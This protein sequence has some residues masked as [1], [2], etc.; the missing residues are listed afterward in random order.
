MSRFDRFLRRV[1]PST[2]LISRSAVF[3]PVLAVSDIVGRGILRATGKHQAVPP[4][5]YIVRTGVG[6]S[7]F[8]PHDYYLT[9]SYP[10]WMYL[11]SRGLASLHSRIV[12]IGSGVGKSAVGLRDFA[13]NGQRF[14]GFYQGYD[15]DPEMV[16]W[17]QANFPSDRFSFTKLDMANSLYSPGQLQRERPALTCESGTIDLVISQSLFSH[18][19]E[20]DIRHY[21][22]ESYRVLRPGGAMLMTFFCLDDMRDQ[23][24]LGGRWTFQHSIGAAQVENPRY[25]ESAVAYRK[26]WML[27]AA[28]DAGFN[29]CSV[30]L[31]A[32]QSTLEC[33][34]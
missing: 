24:L 31:P 3:A 26:D 15:V 12:D 30:I 9:A 17:S 4:L 18:L 19:L 21:L 10:I 27:E 11:F 16:A 14:E 20:D 23:Q 33:I 25:P 13:Y 2:T 28:R 6:N 5:R 8:L 1:F 34:K 22:R 32:A 7:I 29:S